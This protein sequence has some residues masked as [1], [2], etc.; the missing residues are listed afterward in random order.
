MNMPQKNIRLDIQY[1]GGGFSGWQFQPNVI[2]VQGEIEKAIK[3]V[4]GI[5]LRIDAAGRTDAGVHALG[6][7]ANFNID[8]KLPIEKYCEALN[9]YLPDK[10]LISSATEVETTFHSRKSARWRHYRFLIGRSR[11]ALYHKLRWEF[12]HSLNI[13]RMNEIARLIMGVH[14]FAAFCAVSSQKENNDCEIIES[15]W[16]SENDLLIFEIKGNRFLH[17]MVRSLVGLMVQAGGERQRLTLNQFED[18]L[19]SR[20]HR[21][22]KT[23]AP[24]HGLYLVAVGY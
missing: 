15:G 8:H 23:V 2:T 9:F 1:D 17:T 21:L 4:T 7:V 13:E 6:Q 18:I 12:T 24:P 3:K 22:I 16:R 5:E 10:I 20:D 11:S 19:L 14:D